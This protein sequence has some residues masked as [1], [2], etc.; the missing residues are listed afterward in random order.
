MVI[1]FPWSLHP[2]TSPVYFN[3]FPLL[4]IQTLIECE[5][6]FWWTKICD[7]ACGTYVPSNLCMINLFFHRPLT[8]SSILLQRQTT[9]RLVKYLFLLFS[10]DQMVLLLVSVPNI[11]RCNLC[12]VPIY[13]FYH[14]PL[15]KRI[16]IIRWR[17]R[18]FWVHFLQCYAAW[19]AHV[20]GLKVLSPYSA[21]DARG[22]LKAA[23]RDPDPVVFLENE[24]LYELSLLSFIL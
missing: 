15:W 19:Y 9:C 20:P 21:E 14:F 11:L 1:S 17:H 24:L 2:L 18:S 13:Q 16:Q 8:T 3:I 4:L 12:Q 6:W 7:F 5:L 10:E 23:I 22:L